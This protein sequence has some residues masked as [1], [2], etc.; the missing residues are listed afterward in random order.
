M[1]ALI[2]RDDCFVIMLQYLN[3]LSYHYI[4]AGSAET[5]HVSY[6]VALS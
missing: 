1:H 4:C 3:E 6:V 5:A 2:I